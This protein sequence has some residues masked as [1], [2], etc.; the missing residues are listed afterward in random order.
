MSLRKQLE[1]IEGH[2]EHKDR[3]TTMKYRRALKRGRN[4]WIRRSKLPNADK[5]RKGWEF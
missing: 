2:F 5:I 4:K 1:Q 3:R